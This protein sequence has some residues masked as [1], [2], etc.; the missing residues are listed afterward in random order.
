M[1][2]IEPTM[3][4]ED[5]FRE[6]LEEF[7][8]NNIGGFW[9]IEGKPITDVADYIERTKQ[10]SQGLNL[11]KEWVP[12]STYWLIDNHIFVGHVSIRHQLNDFLK[13][14][15]GHIG[16]A[17]RPSQQARGYGSTILKLAL[18]RARELGMT[19]ILITCDEA[20]IA[21]RKIIEKNGGV[22]YQKLQ[23]DG[24]PVLHYWID[25]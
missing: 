8:A 18:P 1:E 11:P 15:G 16:Y 20:N 14:V 4:Y 10:F 5:S 25:L 21:S 22:F 23:V 6:A 2:L 17:V 9:K 24:K 13:R 19:K 12:W 7:E 3:A